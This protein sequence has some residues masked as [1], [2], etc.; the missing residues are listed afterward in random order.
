MQ[1]RI[2]ALLILAIVLVAPLQVATA[3]VAAA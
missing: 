1:S 2:R 3:P